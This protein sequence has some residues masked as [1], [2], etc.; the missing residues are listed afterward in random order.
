[1]Q[2]EVT[3]P[4]VLGL[5][6]GVASIGWALLDLDRRGRPASVRRTGVHLF[7][8]GVD[9]GKVDAETAMTRGKEQSKAKPRRDARSMRRQIWRRARR[10]KKILGTLIR[11]GLLPEGDVRTPAA[12]DSYIKALDGQLRQRWEPRGTSHLDCQKLPYRLREA[13]ATRRVEKD[14]LGRALYHLA[15]RRGFLTNRKAPERED[16]RSEMK[17]SIADLEGLVTAHQPP[18]LGAYLASLDPHEKRIR[19]RWT[20]RRLYRDEFDRIWRT[21]A[22]AHGLTD[23]IREEIKE[24]IFHQ[25]PLKDQSHLIG[26]CSL[27][28][29]APRCPIAM[30]IA[31]RFR[32][33]QQVNH[34]RVIMDDFTDRALTDEERRRLI[35]ALCDEGDLSMAKAKRAAG[36]PAR[37]TF[38]IERGGEKKLIGHRTDARLRDIF[39]DRFDSL[40]EEQRDA[41]VEDMRS[42]RLSETL[43][44]IGRARW[45]LDAEAAARF[46]DLTLEEGHSAHSLRALRR[47]VPPLERGA[48]YSDARQ[49][50][51]PQSF[52]SDQPR[53][54]LPPLAD[55]DRDLRNPSVMRALTELRKL[56]NAIL[57][58]HGK[59]ERI[60]IELARDLKSGRSRREEI[61]RRMRAREQERA[62]AA[63]LITEKLGF[64][65]PRGW[66]IEK[67]LLAEECSWICPFTGHRSTRPGAVAA[68]AAL[69]APA[70]PARCAQRCPQSCKAVP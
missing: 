65:D 23:D 7:E 33:L 36:L 57:R 39:G 69:R 4:Y 58:R 8:A 21:Q 64:R 61:S 40:T 38:S 66:Q 26:R 24:A 1:M 12:I 53:D 11:H 51:F 14:E 55:W 48:S 6:L 46:A 68:S 30:R 32:I 44:K 22:P 27:V 49:A 2:N 35:K 10:K 54:F 70:R 5:D 41:I 37:I 34:L 29:G 67:W 60:H 25:R 50:E 9:G 56:V 43:Y 47:L 45:G 52:G 3:A 15:Q 19:C 59:P 42:V 63:A 62:R 31:Q 13:A 16:D 28:E 18:T 20:S 17:S